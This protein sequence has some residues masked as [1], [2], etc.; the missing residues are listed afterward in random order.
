LKIIY[1]EIKPTT[2]I[3]GLIIFL[4]VIIASSIINKQI[5]N[6]SL[7]FSISLIIGFIFGLKTYVSL[8]RR[9]F[10]KIVISRRFLNIPFDGKE[11]GVEVSVSNNSAIPLLRV[12]ISDHYPEI[13]KMIKGSYIFEGVIPS[14][15]TVKY[16][17]VLK[18]IIGKHRFNPVEIVVSDLFNIFNYKMIVELDDCESI[19]KVKPNPAIIPFD[20]R[21]AITHR[22]L[23]L[24]KTRVKGLGQT[25]YS[26]REYVTGDDY[27]FID[28]KSYARTRK[29]YVKEFEREAN[30]SIVFIIDASLNARR[31]VIG[32]TP[33][34]YTARLISGITMF[35]IKRG[36]WID[37]VVR[38]SDI[39]DSGYSK[40]LNHYY[41]ILDTLASVEWSME[42]SKITLGD[43]L[44]GKAAKIPRRS[45]TIFMII[46]PIT[47]EKD[48]ESIIEAAYKVMNQGHL[49]YVVQLLPEL[50]ELKNIRGLDSALYYGLMYDRVVK[51]RE[52]KDKLNRAGIRV[53]SAGPRDLLAMLLSL[54]EQYRSI[55]V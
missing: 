46:A 35:L 25:F 34:E 17:Y 28:W 8:T 24:G 21:Y 50:F 29:L 49:V 10:D 45:K 27:R 54:I 9:A 1:E 22:G 3:Y 41:K 40:G 15:S 52:N 42:E 14:K 31:G 32:E 36:D 5:D 30:L 18:P 43:I 55:T 19:V 6:K 47:E 12:I 33:F 23:G 13:F 37:V 7:L 2:R 26:L 11:L 20:I 38:S 53:I 4:S 48:A 51:S 44:I 16:V 39:L